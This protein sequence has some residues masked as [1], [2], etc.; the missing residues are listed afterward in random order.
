[1]SSCESSQEAIVHCIVPDQWK[2]PLD[3]RSPRRTLAADSW[4]FLGYRHDA[5]SQ[6]LESFDRIETGAMIV[7]QEFDMRAHKSA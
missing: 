4:P 5:F 1:V 2:T 6:G 7:S 3:A